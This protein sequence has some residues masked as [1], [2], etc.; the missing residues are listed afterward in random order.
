MESRNQTFTFCVERSY[1]GTHLAFGGTLDRRC[2]FK[3]ISLKQN[4]FCHCQTSTAH[5]Y[6]IKVNSSVAIIGIKNFPIGLHVMYLYFLDTPLTLVAAPFVWGSKF[7]RQYRWN[8]S[9]SDM[10]LGVD[11]QIF[12]DVPGQSLFPISKFQA[13]QD[14]AIEVGS[15][16]FYWNVCKWRSIYS[17]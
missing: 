8:L 11:W 1:D 9:S 10:L 3:H 4:W 5:R 12:N 17:T 15:D 13:V 7:R 6:K 2:H 16:R 14:M